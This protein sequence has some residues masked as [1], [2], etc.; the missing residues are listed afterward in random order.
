MDASL[1]L[2]LFEFVPIVIP[3]IDPRQAAW[4]LAEPVLCAQRWIGPKT[5]S[6]GKIGGRPR[7]QEQQP[8]AWR[9]G[10]RGCGPRRARLSL[11]RAQARAGGEDRR[12]RLLRRDPQGQWRRR[13]RGRQ[14]Q[15][16]TEPNRKPHPEESAKRGPLDGWSCFERLWAL[17]NMRSEL[18][19]EH[20]RAGQ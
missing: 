20:G 13:H 12:A 5:I 7:S 15:A 19:H 1:E 17:L 10:R 8:F 2:G 6:E 3:D 4:R 11:L 18:R 9:A 14:G 16:L